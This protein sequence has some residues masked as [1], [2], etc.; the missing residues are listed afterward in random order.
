MRGSPGGSILENLELEL[1]KLLP[2]GREIKVPEYR[3]GIKDPNTA[4]L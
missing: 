3:R 2:K 1:V 4:H